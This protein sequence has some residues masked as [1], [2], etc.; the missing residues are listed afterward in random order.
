MRE[1]VGI[2]PVQSGVH[3]KQMR[4]G[5][6]VRKSDGQHLRAVGNKRGAWPRKH[7]SSS[8]HRPAVGPDARRGIAGRKTLDKSLAHHHGDVASSKLRR[9]EERRNELGKR[10]GPGGRA[11]REHHM[12]TT[13]KKKDNHKKTRH[14]SKTMQLRA[15]NTPDRGDPSWLIRKVEKTK[16]VC[17]FRGVLF[18]RHL[19]LFS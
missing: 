15:R 6:V 7:R 18:S 19:F 11:R 5:D 12:R 4:S 14:L 16:I 3:L 13:Q 9:H 2:G 8:L 1:I 10:D 17:F